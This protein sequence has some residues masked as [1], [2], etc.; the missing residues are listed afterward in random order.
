MFA[1]PPHPLG[2]CDAYFIRSEITIL[3]VIPLLHHHWIHRDNVVSELLLFLA[4]RTIAISSSSKCDATL[5]VMFGILGACPPHFPRIV[6]TNLRR[7]Q[8]TVSILI[9]LSC[10]LRKQMSE[11]LLI[12]Y[13]GLTAKRTTLIVKCSVI[14]RHNVLMFR[15]IRALPPHLTAWMT[16]YVSRF[17]S[18]ILFIQ[19]L[20][21]NRWKAGGQTV[22]YRYSLATTVQTHN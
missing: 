11:T 4:K 10:N 18:I 15:M 20:L 7:F 6:R 13:H 16:S 2:T 1:F 14:R 19:P 21:L 9:P 17:Q 3:F 12:G 8:I 22:C 5:P